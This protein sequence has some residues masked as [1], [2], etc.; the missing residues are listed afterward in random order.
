MLEEEPDKFFK[1]EGWIAV[2]GLPSF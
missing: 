1:D 2:H